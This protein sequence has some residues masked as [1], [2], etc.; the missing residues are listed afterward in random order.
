MHTETP[1]FE[2]A[3]T[4]DLCFYPA[5]APLRKISSYTQ[6]LIDIQMYYWKELDCK[7]IL[8]IRST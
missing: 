7:M 3:R 8:L 6:A 5:S 4:L 1:T 2:F